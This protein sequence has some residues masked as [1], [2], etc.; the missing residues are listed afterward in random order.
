ML[1]GL[2]VRMLKFQVVTISTLLIRRLAIATSFT[3]RGSDVSREFQWSGIRLHEV[4][5]LQQ[6]I[7]WLAQITQSVSNVRALCLQ[8]Q[9][10]DLPN[11]NPAENLWNIINK[12]TDTDSVPKQWGN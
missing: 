10:L 1:T 5:N 2:C 3:Q 9:A 11:L 8:T 6:H 7:F 4:E 12:I